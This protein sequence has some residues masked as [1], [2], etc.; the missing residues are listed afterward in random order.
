MSTRKQDIFTRFTTSVASTLGHAWTFTTALGVLLLWGISGPFLGFS[1]TWQ[2][3][4][5]TSTTIVTFLVVFIIQN[6]QNRD[7][8][9]IN[10]KLDSIMNNLG[11][12]EKAIIEAEDKSDKTLERK[13]KKMQ[14]KN[15]K[16]Q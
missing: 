7:N 8:L 11:I 13:Q 1:D 2:L 16:T 9:A 10:I 6:T 15:G 4:I 12:D 14:Q 3:I 5:N